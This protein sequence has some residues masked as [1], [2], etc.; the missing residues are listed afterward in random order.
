MVNQILPNGFGSKS[1]EDM[2]GYTSE[3]D[4]MRKSHQQAINELKASIPASRLQNSVPLEYDDY[5]I[6]KIED[7]PKM[8]SVDNSDLYQQ[9]EKQ[10]HQPSVEEIQAAFLG[11]PPSAQKKAIDATK[12]FAAPPAPPAKPVAP[13][14][15]EPKVENY[16]RHPVITKLLK[17]FGLKK[18]KKYDLE[19]SID[20]S[21]EKI[22][23]TMVEVTEDLQTW[24]LE[25]AREKLSLDGN[26]TAT[27]YFELLF[28]CCS[29][30]AIEKQPLWEVFSVTPVGNEAERLANNPFDMSL[31]IRKITAQNLCNLLWSETVPFGDK[32]LSFYQEVVMN[33]RVISSMEKENEKRIRFVCPLDNC[34]HYEFILPEE[35]KKYY[36]KFH[37]VPLI[38]TVDLEKEN[39]IPLA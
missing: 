2:E 3:I 11:M 23:Y 17:N 10:R 29:V 16:S 37:G 18:D 15:P 26:T 28:A 22:T 13:P 12:F 1:A 32:L 30:I 7:Q 21:S 38:E 14:P 34:D 4:R 39:D 24:A 8:P 27:V 35:N 36:C 5:G 19:L 9:F 33:K 25:I 6:P 31:R 20:G